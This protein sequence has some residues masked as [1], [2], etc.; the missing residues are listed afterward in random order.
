MLMY[1]ASDIAF[2]GGS[3]V[4]VGGHNLL[5]PAALSL[6]VITGPHLFNFVKISDLLKDAK[7]V[8]VVEKAEELEQAVKRL[9]HS[10][11]T[12]LAMGTR[13]KSVVEQNRGALDKL[14]NILSRLWQ[15]PSHIG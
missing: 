3:L 15:Q 9:I 7:A 5:E 8:T 11:E 14:F 2:V 4:P 10:Q 13:A 6:P 12:C 1:A